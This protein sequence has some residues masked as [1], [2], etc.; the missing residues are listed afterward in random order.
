MN[1]FKL[2]NLMILI[3]F[4]TSAISLNAVWKWEQLPNPNGTDVD[5]T[6]P[7]QLSNDWLCTSTGPIRE[8]CFAYSWKQDVVGIMDSILVQIWS[9]LPDPDGQGPLY[10][11]PGFK[12]WEHWFVPCGSQFLGLGAQSWYD[13]WTST[14]LP[15]DHS[16]YYKRGIWVPDSLLFMQTTGNIYWVSLSVA[17]NDPVNTHVGWKTTSQTLIDES[18]H[19]FNGF[20][21]IY[22]DTP[23]IDRDLAFK[24]SDTWEPDCPCPVELSSF[25]GALMGELCQINWVTA[26]ETNVQGFNIYRN[27]DGLISTA[28]KMNST[29]IAATNTSNTTE[30]HFQDVEIAN[31]QI[32]Y[33]W[34]ESTDY[35]GATN[36]FGP[37][38][39]STYGGIT[40]PP[41][42]VTSLS[43]I[44][45]NP[46]RSINPMVDVSIKNNESGVLS[47][48]NVKGQLVNSFHLQSGT[49]HF[50]WN[51]TDSRNRTCADGV[52]FY[53]LSTPTM[54]Q[55]RKVLILK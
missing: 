54:N 33:Y 21:E 3:V 12:L 25:N 19:F 55:T 28:I 31:D 37:I 30:Y 42:N 26:S 9:D 15:G 20:W 5:M 50:E 11:Q 39:I 16:K 6:Y 36:L 18:V 35:D 46:A 52:Y 24:V 29:L 8:I 40:P 13:P 1:V 4:I 10:S 48:F 41:V 17:L 23:P 7:H 14:Y 51:R 32:Y 34:L 45:P 2:K 27:T 43:T 44:Y 49:Q 47:I 38:N 22:P 53:R